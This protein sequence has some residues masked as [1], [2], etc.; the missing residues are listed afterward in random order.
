M[1]AFLSGA[2]GRDRSITVPGFIARQHGDS[3][4]VH[5]FAAVARAGQSL[6][7]AAALGILS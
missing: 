2:L 3:P 5:L 1:L 4:R 6:Y 7:G